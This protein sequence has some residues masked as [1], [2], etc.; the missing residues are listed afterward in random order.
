MSW[1]LFGRSGSKYQRINK[2]GYN[3]FE[4]IFGDHIRNFYKT[5]VDRFLDS[6]ADI[7]DS[8][9]TKTEIACRQG[10]SLSV[11]GMNISSQLSSFLFNQKNNAEVI[12]RRS[13]AT[14]YVSGMQVA[15]Q[16]IA[17][18]IFGWAPALSK[19]YGHHIVSISHLILK[20]TF[21]STPDESFYQNEDHHMALVTE[22]YKSFY[23]T[24]EIFFRKTKRDLGL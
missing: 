18:I 8:D 7:I 16:Q 13:D 19:C 11:I 23:E 2:E 20:T 3:I 12:D 14:L 10:K 17:R 1:S 22:G 21:D 9:F 15:V 4:E 6:I 24:T 5:D